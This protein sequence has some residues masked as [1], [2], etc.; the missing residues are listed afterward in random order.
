MMHH[1]VRISDGLGNQ[2]FQYAFAFALEKKTGV[3]VLIDPLFWGTSLRRYQLEEFHITGTKRLVGR[4]YIG[5]RAKK[6]KKVQGQVQ[7]VSDSEEV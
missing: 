2:M 6:W 1:V 3:K 4:L 7:A 5:I